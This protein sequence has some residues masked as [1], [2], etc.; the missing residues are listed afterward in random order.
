MDPQLG[1]E[2]KSNKTI[3]KFCRLRGVQ[4]AESRVEH[5]RRVRFHDYTIA[6][7][8]ANNNLEPTDPRDLGVS[9]RH[10]PNADLFFY[11]FANERKE[12]KSK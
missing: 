5:G 2:S 10:D 9:K 4:L 12:K 8:L 6:S 11:N 3:F 7:N 1:M